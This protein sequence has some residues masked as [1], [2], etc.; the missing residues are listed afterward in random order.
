VGE[1]GQSGPIPQPQPLTPS[2]R[3][4]VPRPDAGVYQVTHERRQRRVDGTPTAKDL[5][6]AL[7][8]DLGTVARA[9]ARRV[10]F[11]IIDPGNV[12]LTLKPTNYFQ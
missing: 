12:H 3:F 5:I 2:P 7:P 10:D 11:N 8:N 9:Q 4:C 1:A 6:E